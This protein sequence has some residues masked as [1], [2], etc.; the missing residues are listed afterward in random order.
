[1]TGVARAIIIRPLASALSIIAKIFHVATRPLS[2]VPR[3]FCAVHAYLSFTPRADDI[4]VVTYPRSGTTWMRMILYQLMTDGSMDIQHVARSMPFLEMAMIFGRDVE[5]LPSPR[6]FKTH[7]SY[8]WIPK[9]GRYI[10]VTRDEKD[11]AI[12]YF[13]FYNTLPRR[14]CDFDTFLRRFLRGRVLHGAWFKHVAA[15]QRN[16]AGLEV[17][18]LAYEDLVHDLEESLR[19]IARFC[20]VELSEE[21]LAAVLPRCTFEFMKRHETK[22]DHPNEVLLE[23]GFS[24][25]KFIRQGKVGSWREVLTPEQR[26]GFEKRA[27]LRQTLS[28]GAA[29]AGAA[30]AEA[31][32]EA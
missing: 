13:H 5:Q 31:E 18:H 4:Y 20:R 25:G 7:F 14:S 19:R 26:A 9:P 11:V 22:L 27:A 16:A 3:V 15:W 2:V 29:G 21:R 17:L 6:V 1:M 24:T 28:R 30:K 8:R 23:M 32:A 12:S 10:Y